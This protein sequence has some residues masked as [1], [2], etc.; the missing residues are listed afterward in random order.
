[1]IFVTVGTQLPFERL[2]KAMDEWAEAHPDTDIFAQVGDTE[3]VPKNMKY[4]AKLTPREYA[5]AFAKSKIVVSHAGMGTIISGLENA[6]P[7]ILMPRLKAFGEHRND[8]QLGTARKFC[9]YSQISIVN[10]SEELKI[11]ISN[12]LREVVEDMNGAS[13]ASYKL[14]EK[15]KE[16]VNAP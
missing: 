7:M 5:E 9:H 11:E 4:A 6:K 2:I 12:S 3:Y 13:P 16:F 14:I 1:M 8:H 15:L 10:S